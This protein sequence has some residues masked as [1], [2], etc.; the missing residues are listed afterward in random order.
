[1]RPSALVPAL[2]LAAAVAGA[3]TA[4]N[5]A[6]EAYRSG[7]FRRA[8]RLFADA[9][10]Q[11]SDSVKRADIRVQLAVTEFNLRDRARA[12]EALALA[13]QD[14]PHLE[15][16][17]DFYTPEFMTLFGRAK[18]RAAAPRPTPGPPAAKGTAALTP[19]AIRQRLA[20]AVDSTEVDTIL[21]DIERLETT[22]PAAGLVEVLEL[23]ADAFDRLGR[24]E[25]SLEQRGRVAALRATAL[26]TPNTPVVPLEALLEGRRLIGTGRPQDAESM[27][28]GVLAVLPSCVPA[29]EVLGEAQLESG[30]LD[31]AFTALR[32]AMLGG[33][34]PELWLLL[35]EVEVRRKRLPGARDA[36]RR[37]AESDQGND[38]AL[39]A[40]GLLSA[41][42]ED[43]PSSREYLDRALQANGTL[44]EA[45]VVRG[46]IAL[47]DGQPSAAIT[48]FQRALQVRP[49]DPW[50]IGWMG[51][52]Q[53]TSGEV[54][55]ATGRLRTGARA[56][57]TTFTL[58][59]AEALRREGRH[60]EVLSML[61]TMTGP[62]AEIGLLKARCLIDAGRPGEASATL[63]ALVA[64]HPSDGRIRYLL[65]VALHRER[66]WAAA[67]V[68]LAGAVGMAGAPE[69]AKSA[70][71]NAS[72]AGR[73]QT[74]LDAAHV[75]PP[76]P[77][78]D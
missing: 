45:R 65:G 28:R 3:Q 9:T 78:K 14:N 57:A 34:K 2:L 37:A 61:N 30:K 72:E 68:E 67:E 54:Q 52:A 53:L 35:G 5:Q 32:T 70:A 31:D 40:L 25:D 12:E 27:M 36:F 18:A 60:E 21:L 7:D 66:S 42:M 51:A 56:H 1:M 77:P 38:R 50:A 17:A 76:P 58:A 49:D 59:L 11:E 39:A 22:T 64:Q 55:A 75:P 10:E 47:V 8:A 29:L 43:L 4:L 62:S 63:R 15:L 46:Q 20:Q 71:A 19:V 33:E 13:L 6:A 41:R 73:A 16:V 24:L 44:F 26:A 23:K 74:L 48:H 69:F